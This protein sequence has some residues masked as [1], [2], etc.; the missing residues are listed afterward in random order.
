MWMH[1]TLASWSISLSFTRLG[2]RLTHWALP[3]YH[4]PTCWIG[5]RAQ[6]TLLCRYIH[7]TLAFRYWRHGHMCLRHPPFTSAGSRQLHPSLVKLEFGD[8]PFLILFAFTTRRIG[9]LVEIY[10]SVGTDGCGRRK[11]YQHVVSFHQRRITTIS[12]WSPWTGCSYIIN[13]KVL[14]EHLFIMHST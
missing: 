1:W 6:R 7:C 12:A 10:P 8:T 11:L 5:R 9:D 14:Y 2:R 4:T 13:A 3:T